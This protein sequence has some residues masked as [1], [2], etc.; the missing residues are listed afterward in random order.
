MNAVPPRSPAS[1]DRPGQPAEPQAGSRV[2]PTPRSGVRCW[3]SP[4]L[5]RRR[6]GPSCSPTAPTPRTTSTAWTPGKVLCRAWT[7]SQVWQRL[8]GR[9]QAKRHGTVGIDAEAGPTEI[10][11]LADAGA[12]PGI[13]RRPALPGGARSQCRQR[14]HHRLP[15]PG[16]RRRC[17][18]R[19]QTGTTRH[20]E[21]A[22]TALRGPQSGTVLVRDLPRPSRSPTPTRP[23]T[24]ITPRRPGVASDHNA[25]AIFVGP[26]SPV[27]W[28]TTWPAQPVLP[29]GGTARFAAG[30][31]DGFPQTGQLIEPARAH[32]SP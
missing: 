27:P 11:V 15:A 30:L 28:G 16:R 31:S 22:S 19:A 26:Y 13:G 23:S 12:D 21:R 2:C 25:G 18:A 32:W 4:S 20:R 9:R 1:T 8:R 3:G 29:T 5:C 10:A 6:R 14:P 24:W 7:S 17:G